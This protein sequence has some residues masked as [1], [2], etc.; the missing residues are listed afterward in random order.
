MKGH[1]KKITTSKPGG[2]VQ[3][4]TFSYNERGRL[5]REAKDGVVVFYDDNGHILKVVSGNTLLAI[6][7]NDP[8]GR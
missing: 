8:A 2:E 1:L 7:A 6:V 3:C 4:E 5:L